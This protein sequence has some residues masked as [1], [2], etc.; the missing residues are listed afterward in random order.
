[1]EDL[2]LIGNEMAQTYALTVGQACTLN[3]SDELKQELSKSPFY[4]LVAVD[5]HQKIFTMP[6]QPP[7]M[8]K[9]DFISLI[10]Q[11]VGK[12]CAKARK[13]HPEMHSTH[14]AHSVILEEFEEWWDSV[15]ADTPDDKEL[16]QTAAMCVLAIV[17]LKGKTVNSN[18]DK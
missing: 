18:Y 5:Q 2:K 14:E 15:K 16:V 10:L 4:Y 7:I 12:E 1:M 13:K 9:P 6:P 17:E 11:E 8:S 3:I